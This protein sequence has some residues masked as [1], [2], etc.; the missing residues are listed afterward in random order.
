MNILKVVDGEGLPVNRTVL[1]ISTGY[2]SSS[3]GLHFKK[4][5]KFLKKKSNGINFLLDDAECIG[6]E[7]TL[8]NIVNLHECSDGL[9]K[10]VVHNRTTD[11]ETGTIDSVTW[12]LVPF[13]GK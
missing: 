13:E 2:W 7:E 4:D 8:S 6:V 5:L 10:V 3:N 1:R 11:W 12:K 9:Y